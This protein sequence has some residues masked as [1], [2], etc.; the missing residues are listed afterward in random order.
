MIADLEVPDIAEDEVLLASRRVG[1]CHSDIELLAGRYIIPFD[2]PV[3]PGHEW[4]AE[5]VRT[6][7]SVKSLGV[8]ARV[9]GECVIGADHFG[10]SISGAAAEFFVAKQN[11]L[12]ELP[13]NLSW[14]QGALVE[15]FSCGYYATL[16][17]DDLDASD[18]V[19][20][21]GAGPIGLGIVAAAVGKGARVLVAEPSEARAQLA[22]T[23]G[24]D[25]ALDPT[26]LGFLDEVAALTGGAGASVV[27]EASGRPE[28][29]AVALEAA[30][31]RARLV[32]VG[33]DVG[34]SAPAKLG[35]F[36][37]KELQARGIIGSPGVWPRTLRFLARGGIDLSPLVTS[38]YPLAKADDAVAAVLGD[39]SQVK[40]HLTSSATL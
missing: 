32:Y 6:G 5:V 31:F 20:V 15:P 18:T 17:A 8:G 13:D 1:I 28:A 27:F 35:L 19:L 33:I 4:S 23:L 40:V 3:I 37:S 29:M 16:R 38:A 11:W 14:T 25:T 26:G 21:L 30:A 39:R 9:V 12:H 7:R 36:Q 10:F 24:A 22:R 2:F 34:S